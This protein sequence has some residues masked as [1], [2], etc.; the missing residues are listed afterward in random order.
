MFEPDRL[1]ALVNERLSAAAEEIFRLFERTI[2]D[3]EQEVL[4]SKREVERH[5]GR[6]VCEAPL[7]LSVQHDSHSSEQEHCEEA[8]EEGGIS[9]NSHESKRNRRRKSGLLRQ[10]KSRRLIRKTLCSI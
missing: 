7:H 10:A 5:R 6:F 4:R 2:Q 8:A 3:Y 9:R 1:K